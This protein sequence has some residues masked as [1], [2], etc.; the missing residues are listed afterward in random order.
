MYVKSDAKIV[1][2]SSVHSV[3]AQCCTV[4]ASGEHDVR[5]EFM[6]SIAQIYYRY[7]TVV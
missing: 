6:D 7:P 1:N 2:T 3:R 5:S 4:D